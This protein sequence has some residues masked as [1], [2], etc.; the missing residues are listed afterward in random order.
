M[1]N[2]WLGALL[3]AAC[4]GGDANGHVD[5]GADALAGDA[6]VVDG[7]SDGALDGA[8][9]PLFSDPDIMMRSPDVVDGTSPLDAPILSFVAAQH[10]AVTVE[11]AAAHQATLDE[12]ESA[13]RATSVASADRLATTCG[14]RG[15]SDVAAT[16]DCHRLLGIVSSPASLTLLRERAM[17]AVPTPAEGAH[18]DDASPESY[19]R[20]SAVSALG[21]LARSGDDG[22]AQSL[23]TLV[24]EGDELTR[25]L[26]IDTALRTM[27]RRR[28]MRAVRENLPPEEHWR[29]YEVRP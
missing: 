14:A 12:A 19:A 13:L 2:A 10:E 9:E 25:S 22:A 28:V 15:V 5:A 11:N 26:A 29:L 21:Q 3:L 17:I 7:A 20:S 4:G 23:L 24:E 18:I 6:S 1:R 27:P 16:L 8:E